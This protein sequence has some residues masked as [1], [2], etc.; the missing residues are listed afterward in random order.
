MPSRILSLLLCLA[1]GLSFGRVQAQVSAPSQGGEIR[2]I[3]VTETTMELEFGIGGTGQGRVLALAA[4]VGGMPVPLVAADDHFY[5][6][7][8]AYGQGTTLGAGYAVYSGTGHAATV[9][10]LQ[11]NTYY[12]ITNAEYNAAGASIAYNTRSTSISIATRSAPPAPLPVELTSFT[13]TVDARGM[14]VLHWATATERNTAYFGLER[15][16]DS[17]TFA[18]AGRVAA[19]GTSTR[20]LTYQWPDPQRLTQPTYYRLRQVDRDGAVHYRAVVA[21]APAPRLARRVEVYPVP[22]AGQPVQL[23]LQAYDDEV[24]GLRVSDAVGR[25]LLART[26]APTEAYYLAPLPLPA[27]LASGTYVLTL[28]GSGTPIQKRF[29]VSN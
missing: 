23:L 9:T 11:P 21:L 28:F 18:E 10:G 26:L 4:T 24:V 3:R 22:S 25:V 5:T 6:G 14:A 15:S 12:Y 2:I 16:L 17:S 27:G 8:A 13:G 7:N 19:A 20:P 29:I 1:V